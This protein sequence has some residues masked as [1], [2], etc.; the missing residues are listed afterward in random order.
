MSRMVFVMTV[1]I[2]V[3]VHRAY[4]K[5]FLEGCVCVCKGGGGVA[6]SQSSPGVV[7]SVTP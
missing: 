7:V 3:C 6:Y 2:H 5:V 4:L 1:F